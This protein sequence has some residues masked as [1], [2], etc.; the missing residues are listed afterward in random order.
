MSSQDNR[1]HSQLFKQREARQGI[2]YKCVEKAEGEIRGRCYYPEISNYR[3][4]LRP[5]GLEEQRR[6]WYLKPTSLTL[7]VLLLLPPPPRCSA[8][9]QQLAAPLGL[10]DLLPEWLVPTA[11]GCW[12][13]CA[14]TAEASSCLVL[15]PP[16][17]EPVSAKCQGGWTSRR[18]KIMAF[19]LF[20]NFHSD[21]SLPIGRP[22]QKP[23]GKEL[24]DAQLM[25]SSPQG[26]RKDE[27]RTDCQQRNTE[28]CSYTAF[29]KI[30][31][32]KRE[33]R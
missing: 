20:P 33:K 23:A 12:R 14:A 27:D 31:E 11:V 29:F 30:A 15:P 2:V 17:P 25:G 1:N 5:L 26:E 9:I 3:K 28:H 13:G 18:R 21:T 4:S 8:V 10:V 32:S 24:W 16:A 6:K 7:V 22:N 19:F